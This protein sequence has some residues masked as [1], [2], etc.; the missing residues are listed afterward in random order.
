M[1]FVSAGEKLSSLAQHL[2]LSIFRT[3]TA[4]GSLPTLSPAL[5]FLGHHLT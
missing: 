4:E 1:A 3:P 5:R 2:S